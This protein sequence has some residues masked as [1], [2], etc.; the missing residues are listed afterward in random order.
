MTKENREQRNKRLYEK[1]HR[2][3]INEYIRDMTYECLDAGLLR[4]EVDKETGEEHFFPTAYGLR[5]A[6]EDPS[7]WGI[8]D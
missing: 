7:K 3:A 2:E 4:V 5:L 8:N 6:G 1:A